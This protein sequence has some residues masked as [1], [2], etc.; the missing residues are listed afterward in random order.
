MSEKSRKIQEEQLEQAIFSHTKKPHQERQTGKTIK[1]AAA[2]AKAITE[3][4]SKG[5]DG[6]HQKMPMSGKLAQALAVQRALLPTLLKKGRGQY[7][8]DFKAPGKPTSGSQQQLGKGRTAA[9]TSRPK[10]NSGG[11]SFHFK[12]TFVSKT[13]TGSKDPNA[14]AAGTASAHQRYLERRDAAEREVLRD[15]KQIAKTSST[16]GG[17]QPLSE[18]SSISNPG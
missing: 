6:S 12:H 4:G 5:P 17:L 10:M 9:P 14:R 8:A 13:M 3:A 7:K 18:T 11:V 15:D 1:A 16:I 2:L